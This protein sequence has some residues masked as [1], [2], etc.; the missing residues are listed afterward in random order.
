MSEELHPSLK[1]TIPPARERELSLRGRLSGLSLPILANGWN[2]NPLSPPLFWICGAG[3]L[4]LTSLL[5]LRLDLNYPTT[6]FAFLVIIAV[7]ALFGSLVTSMVFSAAALVCLGYFFVEPAFTFDASNL[8][9]VAALVAFL[10]SSLF[11]TSLIWRVRTLGAIHREQAQLL[12]LTTDAIIVRDQNDLITY[13]N[14]GAEE[15]YGWK[16][17]EAIGHAEHLL[18]RTVFPAPF[19]EL[20]QKLLRTGRWEGE[21]IHT[22]R[23]GAQVSVLSRWSTNQGEQTFGIIESNTDVTQR[24]L[25]DEAARRSEAVYLAEAQQLSKTGSFGWDVATDE[26]FWSAETFRI[27]ELPSSAKPTIDFVL[28][29]IHPDDVD[30][31]QKTFDGAKTAGHSFSLEHRLLMP[32]QVVKFVK[33]VTRATT[34]HKGNLEFI[35]AVM[36]VSAQKRD[37]AELQRSEQRY[38]HLFTRMPIALRQLD[39]TRLVQLFK[40]L[41]RKGVTD[42]AEHFDANPDFLKTCMEALAFREANEHAIRMFSGSSNDTP[43][44]SLVNTWR[45][46]PDTFR[47]AMVS[48]FRGEPSFEEETKMVTWDGRVIDVLFIT[49]RVGSIDDF[50]VSLVGTVDISERVRAQESLRKLQAEFAHA[51]RVSMLGEFTASIAHEINQPL[52]AIRTHGDAGLR[53]LNRANPDLAETQ[54]AIN[55]MLANALRATDIV[56]RIRE[57]ANGGST[58]RSPLCLDDVIAEALVFLQHESQ[59]RG[60]AV[61]HHRGASAVKVL[62][63]KIQLQQVIVN[64]AINSMQAL[65]GAESAHHSITITTAQTEPGMVKCTLEDGGPGIAPENLDRLFDSFFSTKEGGMGM[66]LPICRSIVEAHDGRITAANADARGGAKFC[67]A[68]PVAMEQ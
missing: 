18:L 65:E 17:A 30:L 68:L 34:N 11:V 63:D 2:R 49:A 31:V 7:L 39:A 20:Q 58:E 38:R 66:G 9:D 33:V 35:G 36:D 37:H 28:Q 4:A 44:P 29:R 3:A 24:Y 19:A 52:A 21:L 25:A 23:S 59:S 8:Q 48:R 43:T 6:A 22:A 67:F 53:W 61:V 1:A 27:F 50:E 60:V 54:L 55:G 40:E 13:W 45:A 15:L 51:A 41:R 16:R 57:M 14:R 10:L 32:D 26:L 56:A 12:D 42:L 47:R 62:G 64:L 5:G 46:R